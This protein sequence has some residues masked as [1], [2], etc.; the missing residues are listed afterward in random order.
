MSHL[1]AHRHRWAFWLAAGRGSRPPPRGGSDPEGGAEADDERAR[2]RVDAGSAE[3][4]RNDGDAEHTSEL[5]QRAARACGDADLLGG[6]RGDRG[7]RDGGED[8]GGSGAGDDERH[9]E[10]GEG[11]VLTGDDRKVSRTMLAAPARDS[12]IPSAT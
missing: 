5:A 4:R 6:H 2:G 1:P 8:E 7:V 10:L 3:H 9:T 11:N 12:T